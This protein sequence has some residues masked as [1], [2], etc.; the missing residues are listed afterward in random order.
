MLNRNP[1]H[2]GLSEHPSPRKGMRSRGRFKFAAP[3]ENLEQRLLRSVSQ[4]ANGWTVV[5]PSAN[6]KII[7][8]AP[9]GSDSNSGLSQAAPVKSFKKAESLLVSGQPDEILLESGQTYNDAFLNWIYSGEDPQDPLLVSYY[10]PT[11]ALPVVLPV[12][13]TGTNPAGFATPINQPN[14]NATI[15]YVDVI[16]LQFQANLFNPSSPNFNISGGGGG[17]GL[18]IENPANSLRFED[19]SFSYYHYNMNIEGVEGPISNVTIYRCVDDYAYCPNYGHSQ[20]LYA[21]NVSNISVLQSTFDHDGWDSAVSTSEDLGFNHDI[22]IASTCSGFVAQQNILAEAA[23]AGIMARAGGDID[24]NLFVDDAIAVAYGQANGADST[25]GGVTGTLEGNM[26]VGDKTYDDGQAYGQ[27][28]DIGN[29]D[30]TGGLVVANNIITQDSENAKPA[31]QL[32]A[33]TGTYNPSLCVGENNVTIENNITD[34][35]REGIEIDSRFQDGV[36]PAVAGIYAYNDVTVKDNHFL[37]ASTNEIAHANAWDGATEFWSGDSYYDSVLAQANWTTVAGYAIPFSTWITNYDIGAKQ[38]TSLAQFPNP[39]VSVAGYDA[40]IGGPGSFQDFLANA[41]LMNISNYQSQYQAIAAIDYIQSGFGVAQTTSSGGTGTVGASGPPTASAATLNLN[42]NNVGTTSYT[43]TVNYTDANALKLPSL[44][45]GNLLVTGP[46]GFSQFAAYVSSAT[47]TIDAN[48]YQHV[49]A[50]Y[51]ITAPNGAWGK[52]EDGTYTITMLANQVYDSFGNAVPSGSIG[53][54]VGD[55][56]PPTA[57]ATASNINNLSKGSSSYSFTISYSSAIGI[58]TSTVDN[59][60]VKVTG[61]NGYSQL[62]TVSNVTTTGSTT[63]ATYTVAAPASSWT[64]G[65]YTVSL[66]P[67]T[68]SDLDGNSVTGGTLASFVSQAGTGAVTGT[69]SISGTVF[70]DA[71]GDGLLDD[72]ET[73]LTGVTVFLDLAGTG[74]DASGDPTAT[75]NSSGVYT[76]SNLLAGQYSVDEVA[77]SGYA[78]TAPTA[79]VNTVTLITGQT[80]TNINFANQLSSAVLSGAGSTSATSNSSGGSTTGARI[81]SSGTSSTGTLTAVSVSKTI[82]TLAPISG[83]S[84]IS[85][86]GLVSCTIKPATPKAAT[87]ASATLTSSSLASSPLA[88][89]TLVA[90]SR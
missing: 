85:A 14:N 2:K 59:Y 75:T 24:N 26:V 21:Y 35:F 88:S 44:G 61:P 72:R 18:Y 50:T 90:S 32:D 8:V 49:S 25:V 38:L 22:Y 42:D 29:I 1:Q 13:D 81:G 20:G 55:F 68:V 33:A 10:N 57:V 70:Y 43:F 79:A 12:I 53:T 17:N 63:V 87:P 47:P 45:G 30:P 80:A 34:G 9:T 39:N 52:G 89:S 84:G 86:G 23:F 67:G 40:T 4:D 66:T 56:T 19:D 36:S 62:A 65:T 76:F 74:V 51:S 41:D 64:A 83:V 54:F 16:G 31:I 11:P 5:T 27:G 28:F 73:T 69:A 15:N 3:M 37:N 60:A 6:S 58:D 82:G 78:V 46:D 48:G 77:P 7:Y 71:N